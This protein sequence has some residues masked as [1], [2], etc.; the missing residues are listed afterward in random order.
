MTRPYAHLKVILKEKRVET[1]L[2]N[3]K[4]AIDP[5]TGLPFTEARIKAKQDE[6]VKLVKM[7]KR[8]RLFVTMKDEKPIYPGNNTPWTRK[9]WKYVTSPKWL[10]PINALLPSKRPPRPIQ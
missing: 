2:F 6:W 5:L 9:G 3:G 8:D 7:F 1:E 4:D 10:D